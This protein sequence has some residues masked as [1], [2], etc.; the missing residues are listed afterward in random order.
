MRLEYL[1]DEINVEM[2]KKN[3]IQLYYVRRQS[4]KS[5]RAV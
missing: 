2:L 5:R 1:V 3:L 4:E